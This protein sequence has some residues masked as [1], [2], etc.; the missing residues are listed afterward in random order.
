MT[1]WNEPSDGSLL[2]QSGDS[3]SMANDT[4][5]VEITRVGLDDWYLSLNDINKV[6][7]KRY[8]P[9]VKAEDTAGFFLELMML[10]TEDHNYGLSITVGMYADSHEQD[11]LNRFYIRNGIIEGL[12]GMNKFED[13]KRI[14]HANLEVFPSIKDRFLED[15]G[16]VLPDRIACR[17]KLIDIL[18][19]VDHDYDTAIA[20]LDEFS[21]IGIMNEDEL[22]LRKNSLRIHKMQRSF[23]GIFTYCQK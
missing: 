14:C 23:D 22:E 15:N 2:R 6:K 8:L 7:V 10:S 11:S 17:N 9:K 3:G 1:M 19:G 12:E 20:L 18:V 5:P 21:A 13:A 16:G 4:V